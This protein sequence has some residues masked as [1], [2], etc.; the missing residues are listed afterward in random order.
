VQKHLKPYFFYHL[1]PRTAWVRC[2]EY[3]IWMLSTPECRTP[4]V[5]GTKRNH[6]PAGGKVPA[7]FSLKCPLLNSFSFHLFCL[8]LTLICS[9]YLKPSV[10]ISC[11]S[12]YHSTLLSSR[13][14]CILCPKGTHFIFLVHIHILVQ[15]LNFYLLIIAKVSSTL[16]HLFLL[17]GWDSK[18]RETEKLPIASPLWV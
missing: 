16:C 7:L 3:R 5:G 8:F 17:H 1:T 14:L 15:L 13:C 4:V 10:S 11:S 2:R 9:H 6:T 12:Q 18:T